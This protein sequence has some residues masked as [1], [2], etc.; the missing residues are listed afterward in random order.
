AATLNPAN[1]CMKLNQ[2]SKVPGA[3]LALLTAVF[4]LL[5][6]GQLKADNFFT[7]G[8]LTM[9]GVNGSANINLGNAGAAPSSPVGSHHGW[10]VFALSGGVTLTDP[11]T[12]LTPDVVG[13]I[14]IAGSGNLTMSLSNVVGDVFYDTGSI[15]ANP[16][17]NI[18]GSTTANYNS[19]LSNGV[20]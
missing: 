7:N 16:G 15:N 3:I 14:G 19:Y 4:T 11:T 2:L 1:P 12:G 5:S 8:G 17:S 18:Y 13:D 6:V 20:T 10:A 9:G